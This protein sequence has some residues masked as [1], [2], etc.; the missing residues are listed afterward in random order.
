MLRYVST[1]F[2]FNMS[3]YVPDKSSRLLIFLFVSILQSTLAASQEL[4]DAPSMA[5]ATS[6]YAAE[7]FDTA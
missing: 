1:E 2:D 4:P 6:S 5:M 7:R 3:N